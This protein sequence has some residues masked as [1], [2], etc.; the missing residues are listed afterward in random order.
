MIGLCVTLY[1]MVAFTFMYLVLKH[2]KQNCNAYE[3]TTEFDV[4]RVFGVC[5]LWPLSAI[6]GLV[7][8]IAETVADWSNR[9]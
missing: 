1:L 7:R 8:L 5:I 3:P 6:F 2:Y 9:K 4:Y